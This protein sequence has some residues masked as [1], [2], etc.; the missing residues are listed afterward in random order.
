MAVIATIRQFI[1]EGSKHYDEARATLLG[2]RMLSLLATS[3]AWAIYGATN[4]WAR[5]TDRGS[6]DEVAETIEANVA[7][8]LRRWWSRSRRSRKTCRVKKKVAL[9]REHHLSICIVHLGML[10]DGLR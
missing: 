4:E 8:M 1:V 10:L 2:D 3:A 9:R 6:A 7:P 5:T